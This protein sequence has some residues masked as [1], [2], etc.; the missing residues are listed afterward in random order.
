LTPD[1]V[2]PSHIALSWWGTAAKDGERGSQ[3]EIKPGERWQLT[4]RL[5]RPRGSANPHGF[6]Y[7]AWLFERNVRATGTVRPKSGS[8]RIDAMVHKPAY[9]IEAARERLRE[10]ILQA[11]PDKPYAG[12]LAAA[13]YRRSACDP[14]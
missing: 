1:A 10:R 6:D 8:R 2:I 14:A 11:L 5:R 9:W 3:P 7:E 4:V 12:V 13:G